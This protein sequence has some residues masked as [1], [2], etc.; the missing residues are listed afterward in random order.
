MDLDRY[1]AT[2]GRRDVNSST[3]NP[4]SFHHNELG[5]NYWEIIEKTPGRIDRWNR[6]MEYFSAYDPLVDLFPFNDILKAGNSSERVLAVDIGGG[7]GRALQEV[8]SRCPDLKGRL[9]LQ[10]RTVVVDQIADGEL[11]GIECLAHDFFDIQPV[12]VSNWRTATLFG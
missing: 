6:A 8:K 11:S 12:Q 7:R 2:H 9:I 5:K 10:D 1:H 4:F 3:E